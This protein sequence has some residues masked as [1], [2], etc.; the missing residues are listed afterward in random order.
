VAVHR[1]KQNRLILRLRLDDRVPETR[2]PRYPS[3]RELPVFWQNMIAP[4]RVVGI[5]QF[6]FLEFIRRGDGLHLQHQGE[7][8]DVIDFHAHNPTHTN[9]G[10]NTV[11]PCQWPAVG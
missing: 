6:L 9:A 5:R 1:P 8:D 4:F 7:Q 2:L 11:P 3:V 10:V